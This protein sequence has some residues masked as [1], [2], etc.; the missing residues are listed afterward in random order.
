MVLDSLARPGAEHNL[1]WL[2]RRHGRRLQLA[3][4]D[5]RDHHLVRDAVSRAGSVFHLAAQV[6]VT[7]SLTHPA[8]DFAVNAQGTLNLLEA[9]RRAGHRPPVIFTSTNKVYGH[10]TDLDLRRR[11]NRW[12]PVD[13][14]V[15][16]LGIGEDRPPAFASPYGCSKG[17][18]DQ[19]VLD[20]GACYGIPSLVLRM[21]CIYG[22]HQFGN[23][24]QGW[25][26]HFLINALTGRPLTIYGDGAQVRDLLYVDDLVEA[27]LRAE[28]RAAAVGP[29]AYNLG[30]GPANSLSLLEL[31]TLM[32]SHGLVPRRPYFDDW[33][34]ADQR[35]YVSDT[36]RFRADMGWQ[37][38]W[39]V[40]EGVGALIEWLGRARTPGGARAAAVADPVGGVA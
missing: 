27:L 13:E 22:P 8:E 1:R 6:A 20:Y 34:R 17:A 4:A 33:R 10:L 28:A 23:E 25:V 21:S 32:E 11:G 31:L 37:P 35:W 39:G 3:I 24:D 5:V 30:G 16:G 19:Y 29:R 36:R 9:V 26:A 7:T 38:A 18:A 14:A 2:T 40:R 15:R 12:E